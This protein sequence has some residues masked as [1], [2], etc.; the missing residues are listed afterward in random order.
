MAEMT[1][2]AY[3]ERAWNR[4]KKLGI[5]NTEGTREIRKMS[6]DEILSEFQKVKQKTSELSKIQRDLIV[7]LVI[8][9]ML[10]EIPTNLTDIQDTAERSLS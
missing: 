5:P 1:F 10:L 6:A 2:E 9:A 4:A 3:L 8:N 7:F